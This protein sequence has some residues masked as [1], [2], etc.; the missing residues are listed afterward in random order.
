MHCHT[1]FS[2]NAYGYSPSRFAWEAWKGGLEA[3]GIVDFDCLD[4]TGEFL[5]AG[6]LLGLKTAAGFET[7]AFIPEYS[8]KVIN[9]PKEP[10]VFYLAGT[11]FVEPPSPDSSPGITLAE[12]RA[13]ARRRN[14]SMIK[15][16]NDYLSPVELDY[17]EDVLALTPAGNATERHIVGAY[18]KKAREIYPKNDD[19]KL[20]EFWSEKLD[21]SPAEI[22]PLLSDAVA[23]KNLIRKKL[24]KYGGVG[25]SQPDEGTFPNIDKVIEMTLQCGAMP[26]A[27]WLDGT[28]PG[29]ADPEKHFGFLRGKGC[30]SITLIPERNW[31]VPES[32]RGEKVANLD[33]AIAAAR[34][35]GMPIL[36]GTEMNKYGQRLVDNFDAEALKPH[37]EEFRKG[38]NIAW[39]H[40]LLKQTA[41]IG[42]TGEWSESYFGA[43]TGEKNEFFKSVGELCRPD[44]MGISSLEDAGPNATPV[45]ILKMI[46]AGL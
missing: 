44:R 24:M 18:E 36:A 43:K 41:G 4:G 32:E 30:C 3:A 20:T 46:R 35:L 33:A 9:S 34:D 45:E 29:E 19:D 16:I 7:R 10:G 11:G 23:L 26:C 1:F 27:C 22:K 25:Y 28:T 12:M 39:G 21:S 8:D 31:N 13:G 5:T 14:E 40:T 15:K 42:Y 37:L 17:E 6:R 38:A 2:Y